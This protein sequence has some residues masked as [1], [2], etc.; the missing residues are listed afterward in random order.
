MNCDTAF[1]LMTEA[2]GSRSGALAQ[3]FDSCPRCRRMQEALSPALDFLVEG[4]EFESTGDRAHSDV[5]CSREPFVTTEAIQVARQASVN[6]AAR[7]EMPRVQLARLAGRS[8][9]Y[10]AAFAAGLL[11]AMIVFTQRD[12]SLPPAEASCTRREA[13]KDDPSRTTDQIQAIVHSCAVCHQ[14]TSPGRNDQSTTNPARNRSWDWL[15]PLLEQRHQ[16]PADDVLDLPAGPIIAASE[17]PFRMH[18][19][20]A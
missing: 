6:L 8:A 4:S 7:G 3:H 20:D 13:W 5:S 10:V 2:H 18:A 11:L 19:C 15:I 1:D 14:S 9:K 16:Q 17:K 12:R